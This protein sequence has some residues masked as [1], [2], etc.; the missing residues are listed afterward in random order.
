MAECMLKIKISV[1][2]IGVDKFKKKT[3]I[4]KEQIHVHAYIAV[5]LVTKIT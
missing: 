2:R 5:F 1:N 4:Y 3:S